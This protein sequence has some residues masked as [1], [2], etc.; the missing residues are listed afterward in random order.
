[1]FQLKF[2]ENLE[3]KE[4]ILDYWKDTKD[5]PEEVQDFIKDIS[6]TRAIHEY[7]TGSFYCPIC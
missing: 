7:E 1:M 2:D 4:E 3:I 6:N 5:I